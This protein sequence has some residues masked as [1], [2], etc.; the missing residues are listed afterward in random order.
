MAGTDSISSSGMN[1]GGYSQ[2]GSQK[3]KAIAQITDTKP[4]LS[5]SKGVKYK[6]GAV[7]DKIYTVSKD[8]STTG[9]MP[10]P[11]VLRVT[12]DGGTPVVIM[13]G[14]ET[15]SAVGTS[16]NNVQYLH[17][18]VLPGENIIL[19]VRAAISTHTDG[20]LLDGT[21][22]DNATPAAAMKA[23]LASALDGAVSSTSATTFNVDND[24]GSPSAAVGF[25]RIGD[26]IRIDNEILEITA[27]A[28]NTGTEAQLTVRRGVDGSAAATH[29]DDAVISLAF[30]NGY[31]K[32]DKYS[33]PQTDTSGKYK[34]TN[35]FGVGRVNG[36]AVDALQGITP[37][38][39]ALKF[40]TEGGW[41][42]LGLSGITNGTITGLAASTTYAFNIAVDGGSVF[43]NLSF[44]TDATNLRFGGV[45]GLI[46]KLQNA[47]D[48]QYYTAGNLFE[49]KVSVG[50]V[51]GDLRFSSGSNLS[52]SAIALAA[53]SSGTTP[54][55]V[56][57]FPAVGDV[58]TEA[59]RLPDDVIYDSVTYASNPNQ[60]VFAYDDG[61]GNIFGAARGTINY[62]TGAI[63]FT[64][65]KEAEFV[66]SVIHSGAFSG[67]LD[68]E[69][70]HKNS[71]VD[72]Y[73]NTTSQKWNGSVLVE[74]W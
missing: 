44:T 13:S 26:K 51:D 74:G 31:Q 71:L 66:Y 57:R 54:F 72:V 25:Y 53:P 43:A 2:R 58:R 46:E 41:Q 5:K 7:S 42:S 22:V 39:F 27:I 61:Q 52:T 20:H 21:A 9:A 18:L 3:G 14:Y 30:H 62:E 50:I 64:G 12:N 73:A 34:A 70:T 16:A 32:F 47:F 45:N 69:D 29:A 48:A 8:V 24:A 37:G 60:K 36:V 10:I 15:Y 33:L 38:S 40:Y 59:K 67:K 63:D 6:S 17:S 28:E 35:M 23:A 11:K 19:P 4:V 68:S 49:K 1:T 55:G 56:G 65:P